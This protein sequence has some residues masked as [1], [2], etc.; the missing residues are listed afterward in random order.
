MGTQQAKRGSRPDLFGLPAGK[1]AA[2]VWN[3]QFQIVEGS[4]ELSLSCVLMFARTFHKPHTPFIHPPAHYGHQNPSLYYP[5]SE[6]PPLF[7]GSRR[8]LCLFTCARRDAFHA[9][10]VSSHSLLIWASLIHSCD[11]FG[12]PLWPQTHL[13]AQPQSTALCSV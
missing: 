5:P 13:H 3:I 9:E 11:P 4:R 2:S 6:R 8:H 10:T 12:S 7:L 1:P